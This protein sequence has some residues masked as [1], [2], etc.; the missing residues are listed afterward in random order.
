MSKITLRPPKGKEEFDQL[1]A[2]AT[3][4]KHLVLHPSHFIVKEGEPVGFLSIFSAPIVIAYFSEEKCNARDSIRAIE[5]AETH[6]R[7]LGHK[8][9]FV[10]CTNYSPF[11]KVMGKMGYKQVFQTNLMT[12]EL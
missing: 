12:K 10:L 5:A 7:A 2:L 4:E 11:Y 3:K 6:M 9:Y 1:V 8:H